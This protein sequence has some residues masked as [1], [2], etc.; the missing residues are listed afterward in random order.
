[1]K[2]LI[3]NQISPNLKF[4]DFLIGLSGVFSF[5]K[6]LNFEQFFSTRNYLL[7]NAARTGLSKIIEILNLPQSKKTVGIPAFCCGVM[8]TPFLT[9]KFKIIWIDTDK[10]GNILYKDFVQKSDSISILLLP[11]IFGQTLELNKFYKICQE[12]NIFC[13][14]DCAH[15]FVPTSSKQVFEVDAKILSFGREK[16]FSCVSGGAVLWRENSPFYEK[17]IEAGKSLPKAKKT[18]TAK[19]L[20]QIFIFSIALPW[21]FYGGKMLPFIAQ[22]LKLLPFAVT[23]KEKEGFEDFPQTTLP[24]PLQKILSHQ[25]SQSQQIQNHRK[26]MAHEWKKVLSELFPKS[27]IIIPPNFFRVILKVENSDIRKKIFLRAKKAG[28]LLQEWNGCPIA[29]QNINLENFQ[30]KTGLCQSSEDFSNTYLTFPTNI[31]INQKDILNFKRIF[32]SQKSI[33]LA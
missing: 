9:K 19:H 2:K 21:W 16:T 31:R 29:P 30:Y 3:S 28:F 6:D 20:F 24:F 33:Y 14:E 5:K 22:K 23:P 7:C 1:M 13:I 32:T 26:A 25:L 17:F 10:N 15:S 18:W 12:K 27:E 8:A 4:T 11:H